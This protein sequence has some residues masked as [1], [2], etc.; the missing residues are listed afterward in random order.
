VT[1]NTRESRLRVPSGRRILEIMRLTHF[2]HSCVLVELNGSKIL[3]DPGNFSHGFE[4]ITGLDA[5][6]VTHQHPDHADPARLPEL[7]EANPDAVLYSDP[8]TAEKLGGRWTGVRPGD[9]FSF[10][11]VEV[12]GTGGEHAII[13]PDLPMIDNTA[14]LLGDATNPAR[15]MHP[16]D[17]LYVPEQKV[18]VLALPA[19]APWLKISEAIDYL[20]A[21]AP[22]V[23]VPIHQA[24]IRDEAAGIFYG[25]YSE[26]AAD[27]TEFRVL[28]EESS[29]E[30]A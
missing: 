5:I 9:R 1:A 13:H 14:F 22:R 2:G 7:A 3:F 28:G 23:A 15:F 29:V 21:V 19:A 8:Q 27:G 11:D 4:G 26:M 10:G 30:V 25:R 17:S 16:G 24:I 12:T 6:L 18:D 20:R